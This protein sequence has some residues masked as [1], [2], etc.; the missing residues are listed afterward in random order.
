M[1]CWYTLGVPARRA[2][3]VHP[4]GGAP[5]LR[6]ARHRRRLRTGTHETVTDKPTTAG[7]DAGGAG[8]RDVVFHSAA[9]SI[10]P[11]DTNGTS[12]IFVRRFYWRTPFRHRPR[13]HRGAPGAGVGRLVGPSW[14]HGPPAPFAPVPPQG[15]ARR[16]RV[17][18][19]AGCSRPRTRRCRRRGRASSPARAS[20]RGCPARRR[21][22]R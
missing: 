20:P 16:D 18:R 14:P 11:G 10:V 17:V 21:R 22:P 7:P 15:V 4:R 13:I 2:P 9:D 6:R 5:A 12:D 1:Y 19:T 8:G 3:G